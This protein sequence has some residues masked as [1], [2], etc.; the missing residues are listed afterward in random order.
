MSAAK[1]AVWQFDHLV[2]E[3]QRIA[4]HVSARAPSPTIELSAGYERYIAGRRD[5]GTAYVRKT[6]GLARKLEREHGGLIFTLH[7]PGDE[8]MAQLISWK[9]EQYMR[10]GTAD[11]FG[12]PWTTNLLRNIAGTE[13][14]DFSGQ[15]S[16][17]RVGDR[18]VAAHMGM[19][20]REVMHYWFPAYDPAFGKFSVGIILLLRMAAVL[21]GMGIQ[22]ID[23]GKGDS[24]YK[25]R[26]MTGAIE[27]SEGAVEL[28]SLLGRGRYL[29]R[30]VDSLAQRERKLS[31][32]RT[33][34]K[35]VRRIQTARR[36]Q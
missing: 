30:L 9:R 6:E 2:G 17:L 23:L 35:L 34:S 8:L 27:V 29:M 36:F 25:Q 19:R 1:L 32:F 26:L 28:P 18:M 20:S 4:P 16:V 31:P 14:A 12:V 7:H 22:R 13:T 5:A 21:S 33:L 11:A 24:P 10:A 15:L 3:T